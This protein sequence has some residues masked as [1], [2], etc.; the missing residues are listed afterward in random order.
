MD[1]KKRMKSVIV[2]I[3]TASIQM[4][5]SIIIYELKSFEYAILF[6]IANFVYLFVKYKEQGNANP[7]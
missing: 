3:I 4:S 5:F 6:S 1:S 2:A 7:L